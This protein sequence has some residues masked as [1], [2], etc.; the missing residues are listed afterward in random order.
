MRKE[1]E[2]RYQSVSELAHDIE[3]YLKGAPLVAGPES[4]TYRLKKYIRRERISLS[5]VL[6]VEIFAISMIVGFTLFTR[7]EQKGFFLTTISVADRDNL[8]QEYKSSFIRKNPHLKKA[9]LAI[10]NNNFET[11]KN[12]IESD[13]TVIKDEDCFGR[14]LMYYAIMSDDKDIAKMLIDAGISLKCNDKDGNTPLHWAMSKFPINKELLT[15]LISNGLTFDQMNN[16]GLAPLHYMCLRSHNIITSAD[17]KSIKHVIEDYNLNVNL[18]D[19]Q[20]RTPIHLIC[21]CTRS[22]R[23]VEIII[24]NGADVQARDSQGRTPL[25]LC[26]LNECLAI[27]AYAGNSLEE[28]FVN[29]LIDNGADIN[30]KDNEGNTA[31]HY[32]VLMEKEVISNILIQHGAN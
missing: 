6:F 12:V 10:I 7:H 5:V 15:L 28:K 1:S 23:L 26:A 29:I 3:N 11:A 24:E 30:A 20:G 25:M 21:H 31:L 22:F 19:R 9:A 32:A 8:I 13:F 27:N 18:K 14:S 4:N 17:K 2:H 16:E